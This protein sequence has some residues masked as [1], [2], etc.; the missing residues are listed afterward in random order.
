MWGDGGEQEET[1]DLILTP[2][3]GQQYRDGNIMWFD[4][5]LCAVQAMASNSWVFR[6]LGHLSSTGLAGELK[7]SAL[8]RHIVDIESQNLPRR[9][10]W[11][12]GPTT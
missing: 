10:F 1:F 11:K 8:S 4:H 9:L 3:W 2:S 12:G 7:G 5:M 6:P